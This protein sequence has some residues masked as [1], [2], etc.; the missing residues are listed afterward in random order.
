M[1]ES[2]RQPIAEPEE[3]E[4]VL[5]VFHFDERASAASGL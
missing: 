3:H 1:P 2:T 5:D 4:T